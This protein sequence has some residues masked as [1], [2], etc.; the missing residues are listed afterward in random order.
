V[1]IIG[2]LVQFVRL[3]TR[4]PH[5]EAHHF[6]KMSDRKIRIDATASLIKDNANVGQRIRRGSMSTTRVA[7][8]PYR[9]IRV[10]PRLTGE[11]RA[12]A[13]KRIATRI[14][15]QRQRDQMKHPSP[16]PNITTGLVW[17]RVVDEWWEEIRALLAKYLRAS[18]LAAIEL[19]DDASANAAERLRIIDEVKATRDAKLAQCLE[20]ACANAPDI[21]WVLTTPGWEA[22]LH[23]C[24]W[25]NRLQENYR[26][27]DVYDAE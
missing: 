10:D 26:T 7:V 19:T 24:Q 22:F 16:L 14:F 5:S 12:R 18:N 25:S 1:P 21:G 27:M 8:P 6:R 2:A 20:S 3:R 13:Q 17:W 23:L 11:G 4:Y 15:K 9:Y